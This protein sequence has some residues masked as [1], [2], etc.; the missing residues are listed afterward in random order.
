MDVP[1]AAASAPTPRSGLFYGWVLVGML[2]ITQ[3]ITWGIVYYGFTVLLPVLEAEQGWTRGQM[4][5]AFSL[6]I[7]LSGLGA[8]P[9]GRWLDA[10][11]PRLLMT[12]GS[13]AATLLL[14][15]LSQVTSLLQFYVVWAL[16]GLTMSAIL[17]EPAFAVV[18]A[19]FERKRTRAITSVTLMAGF[20]STVFMPVA[21]WLIELQGWRMALVTLASF[22]ALT[23]IPAH[24]LMLRRRPED[25]GLHVDGET[26]TAAES[27]GR[28]HGA[29]P[30]PAISVAA[31]LREPAF[32]WLALAFSL[33]TVT[34]IAIGV[35]LV[36]Y[37]QDRQYDPAFAATATGMVGAMQVAGRVVLMILGDRFSF[38]G[39]SAVVLAIQPVSILVLLLAPGVAGVWAFIFLFGMMKGALTLL[40]PAVVVHL[41]GRERYAT[42]AGALTAFVMGATALAPIS[43]GVAYDVLHGY[44]LLLWSFVVLSALPVGA[45]LLARR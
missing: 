6:A 25:L 24:A 41:Y 7:L 22:L 9:V 43:A 34:N 40:R 36:A 44:D 33:A 16:L 18:T 32:R 11:G 8:A 12:A 17:Y 13:V 38:R 19:W 31:A 14:L 35:H 20:A 15:A 3:T 23:T 1:S 45:V 28:P 5:G 42:M 27:S 21:S 10:R 4:S 37:L 30:R 26:P 2:G 29:K 39:T